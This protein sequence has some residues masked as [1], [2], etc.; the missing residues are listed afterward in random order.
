MSDEAASDL[1]YGTT[2]LTWTVLSNMKGFAGIVR[3]VD[4]AKT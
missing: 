3:R 2:L 1:Y 4:H